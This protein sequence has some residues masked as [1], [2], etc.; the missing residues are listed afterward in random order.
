MRP[1]KLGGA[2]ALV[3][4]LALAATWTVRRLDGQD[5]TVEVT[6][7]IEGLQVDVS[8]R[9]TARIVERTVKEGEP[10]ERVQRLVT[11]ADK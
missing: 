3:L 2:G 5:R 6:G 1:L 7:T 8:A 4:L 11:L 9:I 10:V